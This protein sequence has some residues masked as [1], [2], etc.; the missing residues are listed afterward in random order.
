ME[1]AFEVLASRSPP[2]VLREMER[3]RRP[4]SMKP[5]RQYEAECKDERDAVVRKAGESERVR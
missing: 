5:R 2:P 4:A 3:A 1:I